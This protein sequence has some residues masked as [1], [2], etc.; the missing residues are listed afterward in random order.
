[1][2]VTVLGKSPAWEDAAGACSGYLIRHE[3]YTLLLDCGNGVFAKLRSEIDYASVDA[4]V[5]THLHADHFFD[6]VPYSFALGH[7]VRSAPACPQLHGPPGAGA[8]FASVGGA[9]GDR[10]LIAGAF[11]LH[12]YDPAAALML[13]P[14][15]LRFCEVPHFVLTHAIRISAPGSGA[16]EV[17]FGADCRPNAALPAFAAG[18]DLM[19]V[20]ATLREPEPSGSLGHLTAREAGEHGRAAAA[21]RL[22]LTHFSDELDP[23]RVR[24]DGS[25][26]YGGEVELAAEGLGF[27]L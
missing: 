2:Q 8:C 11:A 1:L 25:A 19:F 3:G 14:L 23:V 22:V 10:S 17:T 21:R 9:L 20:E 5:L 24:A 15:Q 4:V 7:G 26:G 12:E 13:G 27:K 18:T 6:L 16:G